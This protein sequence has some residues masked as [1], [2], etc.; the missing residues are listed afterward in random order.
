LW[1]EFS[2]GRAIETRYVERRADGSWQFASYYLHANC[3]HCHNSVGSLA[4]LDLALTQSVA[5]PTDSA[6]QVLRSIIDI[7]SEFR[8]KG[9]ALMRVS[10]GSHSTSVLALRM[11]SRDPIE[12]MPPLGTQLVDSDARNLVFRWIQELQTQS[13]PQ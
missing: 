1:K 7:P 13:Q 9:H 6:A 4:P 8:P 11:D 10:P 12:Q 2:H 5:H 3:G